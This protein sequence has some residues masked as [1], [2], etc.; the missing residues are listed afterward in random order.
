MLFRVYG[1]GC[2]VYVGLKGSKVDFGGPIYRQA[3]VGR[4]SSVFAVIGGSAGY[5][6]DRVD[7][8][9]HLVVAGSISGKQIRMLTGSPYHYQPQV[10]L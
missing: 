4:S 8:K 9:I 7:V 6:W 5:A 1:L 10:T 2:R 3:G